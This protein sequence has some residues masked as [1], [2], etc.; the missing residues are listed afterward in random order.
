MYAIVANIVV[1]FFLIAASDKRH[2]TT[3]VRPLPYMPVYTARFP[4]LTEHLSLAGILL[5]RL[6]ITSNIT[7]DGLIRSGTECFIAVPIWQQWTSTG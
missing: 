2:M 3:A 4:I 1:A 7:I 5:K 6:N